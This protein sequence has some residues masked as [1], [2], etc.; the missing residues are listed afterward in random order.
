KPHVNEI[1]GKLDEISK[2]VKI[3]VPT[4]LQ[5]PEEAPLQQYGNAVSA[6]IKRVMSGTFESTSEQITEQIQ[7]IET[8]LEQGGV[9]NKLGEFIEISPAQRQSLIQARDRLKEI[10]GIGQ[11]IWDRMRELPSIFSDMSR[12]TEGLSSGLSK[13]FD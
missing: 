1:Q 5:L 4:E 8:A 12:S 3:E 6:F 9:K 11:S 13:A 2:N 7:T 10:L